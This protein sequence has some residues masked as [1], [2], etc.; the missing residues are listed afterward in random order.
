LAANLF[1]VGL[2]LAFPVIGLMLMADISLA[3]LGRISSQLH[4]SQQAF[5]AKMLIGLLT[6]VS[7]L[8]VVPNL[9]QAFAANVLETIQSALT[10]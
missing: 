4:I 9:Y 10:R 5:P 7:V 6:L 8:V 1:S 2:R 3:L